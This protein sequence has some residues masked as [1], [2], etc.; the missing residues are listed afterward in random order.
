MYATRKSSHVSRPVCA[1]YDAVPLNAK[2][3]NLVLLEK[4]GYLWLMKCACGRE[5]NFMRHEVLKN[6]GYGRTSCG[7]CKPPR[8][9]PKKR[10]KVTAHEESTL[11]PWVYQLAQSTRWIENDEAMT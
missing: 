2:F 11:A 10:I 6:Q 9:K 3:G 8:K 4:C 7:Q 1:S 5:K